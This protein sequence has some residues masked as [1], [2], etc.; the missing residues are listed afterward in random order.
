[1]G[2]YISQLMAKLVA[3]WGTTLTTAGRDLLKAST[4]RRICGAELTTTRV[5][6]LFG[7]YFATALAS[8]SVPRKPSDCGIH[9]I[10]SAAIPR[11]AR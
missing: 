3:A 7:R 5:L 6:T 11:Q 9:R 2:L 8:V 1:M 4:D 10:L